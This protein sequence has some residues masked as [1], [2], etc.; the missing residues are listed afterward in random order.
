MLHFPKAL[1]TCL[2]AQACL[3]AQVDSRVQ[4]IEK[5]RDEKTTHLT[6][7][8]PSPWESRLIYIKDKKILERFSYGL[9]GV[10]VAF[11]QMGTGGG[12]ALG[13]DYLR[14]DLARGEL[15]LH[16]GAYASTRQWTKLIAEVGAPKFVDNKLFWHL[17][18]VYHNYNSIPYYGPGPESEKENR[19]NYRYEDVAFD[20]TLGVQPVKYLRFGGSLGYLR[21]NTGPGQDNRY[22]SSDA[23]FPLVTGM[24]RQTDFA[25]WG[26]FVQVDYRDSEIGPRAGGN[27][28][29]RWDDYQNQSLGLHS[30]RRMDAEAQ[31]F[32]PVFNKR[33]VFALRGRTILSYP[34]LNQSVPFYMQAVLGGSDDLRGFRPYRFYDD[35]M[36]VMNAEYR[37]ETF[38]GLDMAVFADAGKVTARR[39]DIN[40]KELE[41]AVGFGLRFNI[42]NA[43]FLR[44]DVGF[45]HEGFMVWLKFGGLFAPRP[46]GASSPSFIR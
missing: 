14:T 30:F 7:D 20:S 8:N 13:P 46:Y 2:L 45:S 35:N 31:Q 33:R 24:Q 37:W 21:V 27:Y 38:S 17:Q 23:G 3:I 26:T 10:R 18:G 40:F 42:R 28:I 15:Q 44:V 1:G 41:S 39:S 43:T 5:A 11:G 32:I 9:A 16:A 29:F 12:F 4:E 22:Q 34:N 19:T 25:R 6:P 36:L